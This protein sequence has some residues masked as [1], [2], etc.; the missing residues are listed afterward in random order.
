MSNITCS[1]GPVWILFFCSGRFYVRNFSSE[2]NDQALPQNSLSRLLFKLSYLKQA[3]IVKLR[4]WLKLH[5]TYKVIWEEYACSPGM[6]LNFSQLGCSRDH[7]ESWSCFASG[8]FYMLCVIL[9]C[10]TCGGHKGCQILWSWSY[11]WLWSIGYG[12]WEQNLGPLRE[13]QVFLTSKP[14]LQP[15]NSIV[16]CSHVQCGGP[17]TFVHGLMLCSCGQPPCSLWPHFSPNGTFFLQHWQVLHQS[18]SDREQQRPQR[19]LP[20]I[21]ICSHRTPKKS[22]LMQISSPGLKT[23]CRP[24]SWR[25]DLVGDRQYRSAWIVQQ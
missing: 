19:H 1:W 24:P 16:S 5:G 8:H 9:M 22:H 17:L 6:M 11:R 7:L 12:Y 13:N 2:C 18:P 23:L 20:L 10:S 25:F 21:P 4:S 15:H 3:E 14:S